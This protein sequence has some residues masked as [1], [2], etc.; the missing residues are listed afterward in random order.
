MAVKA[1]LSLVEGD[2]AAALEHLAAARRLLG[3]LRSEVSHHE[4]QHW[5]FPA[6][7]DWRCA[8]A[9]VI[10]L[11]VAEAVLGHDLDAADL[12]APIRD[13]AEWQIQALRLDSA[14][15]GVCKVLREHALLQDLSGPPE[16][17]KR[18]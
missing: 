9:A 11:A 15:G 6:D 16:G 4:A 17:L 8:H 14:L 3:G 2:R 1:L 13:C 12:L 5:D 18:F 7:L 10:D